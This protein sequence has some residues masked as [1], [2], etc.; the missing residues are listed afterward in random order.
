MNSQILVVDF[1]SQV[2]KLIARRVREN[3]VYCEI[4]PFQKI[5][6][7]FLKS[8]NFKGFILSG[9]PCSV[10]DS[11]Y[12]KLKRK[13]FE[14]KVPI[15]GICYGAQLITKI[16]GGKVE[17]CKKREFGLA[18]LKKTKNSKLIDS[19]NFEKF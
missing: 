5:N 12:P 1:G 11:N 16:L 9:S 19:I 7:N 2:T 3:G 17:S 6:E 10:D 18:N 8:R 4:E 15:L 13:F 14:K